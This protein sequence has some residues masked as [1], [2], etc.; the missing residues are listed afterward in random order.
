MDSKLIKQIQDKKGFDVFSRYD[1]CLSYGKGC[2][3]YDFEGKE[4]TDFFAG[5]AVNCLGYGDEDIAEAIST[6]AKK[7]MHTSNFFYNE[8]QAK[9]IDIL[10][11]DTG[12][13]R[14]FLCNSGAEANEAAIKLAR[15]YFYNK[16][17]K[18]FKIITALNSFHGRTITTAT[19]TGQPKYS[20][21]YK[22]LTPGFVYVPFNNIEALKEA[23]NDGEA[24]ALMLETIQGEGGVIPA[25]EEYIKA[26]ADTAKQKGVLFIIDEVQTG[27]M[28]CGSLFSFEKFGIMPDIVTLAKGLG[29]GFPIGAMLARG[30][31][32]EAFKKGDHGSTFGGNPLSCACAN[33]VLN[34]INKKEFAKSVTEKGK[35]FKSAL[36]FLKKYGFCK[37]ARG[38]GLLI[39]LPLD[40]S[41]NG[42]EIVKR[43]L[44]KGFIINC[45]GHNTLR[46]APPLI[47]S[48]EEIDK[49]VKA[50][51]EVFDTINS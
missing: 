23:L 44:E 34:K 19:A 1:I 6:Q 41:V 4:Y 28:R 3:L 32:A 24:A 16:G 31:P 43:M 15:K 7:L 5:I 2:K 17:I 30:E 40:E 11:K 18:R 49:M 50:L 9:L 26:A 25:S 22:P 51:E 33:A 39:G 42:K 47:V 37:E 27:I 21:A 29:G 35:Y 12:F 38:E 46:F 48:K 45:T 14:A 8:E 36:A 10:T 20:E 13:D